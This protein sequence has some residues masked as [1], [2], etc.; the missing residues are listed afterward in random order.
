MKLTRSLFTGAVALAVCWSGFNAGMTPAI[1][2]DP[3]KTDSK[4]NK[5][6]N[7]TAAER[8]ADREM[9]RISDVLPHT[10]FRASD[11]IGVNIQNKQGGEIGDVENIVLHLGKGHV[12]YVVMAKGEF[13]ELGGDRY[14]IPLAAFKQRIQDDTTFLQLD[15]TADQLAKAPD[16]KGEKWPVVVDYKWLGTVYTFGFRPDGNP[17][18]DQQSSDAK[19]SDRPRRDQ[20]QKNQ[21]D[22][23]EQKSED[24]SEKKSQPAA[25]A[26]DKKVARKKNRSARRTEERSEH[27][28]PAAV[29]IA[30][31][32]ELSGHLA[33]FSDFEG[34][35]VRSSDDRKVGEISDIVIKQKN[36]QIAYAV[37][38]RGGVLGI[39]ASNVAVPMNAF[40]ADHSD[41]EVVLRIA[42]SEQRF[43]ETAALNEKSWPT[44]ARVA[45]LPESREK[46][47]N[48][49]KQRSN[50]KKTTPSDDRDSSDE[51]TN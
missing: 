18:R 43:N 23:A 7:D 9:A 3:Q 39:G 14:A 4:P 38:S 41:D 2:K 51:E 17:A 40:T 15:V 21:D 22:D 20:K 12:E 46:R 10:H 30:V 28:I 48:D 26:P 13:L 19:K 33:K 44:T 49:A 5:A 1:A 34:I 37:V 29:T 35:S 8:A 42:A 47:R 16:L 45:W 36:G 11:L 31:S 6:K 25:D 50:Q 27:G 32:A 24:R